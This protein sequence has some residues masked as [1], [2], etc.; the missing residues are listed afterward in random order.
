MLKQQELQKN[1]KLLELLQKKL[2][3]LLRPLLNKQLL[4]KRRDNVLL[5]NK[6]SRD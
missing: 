6:R 4:R 5:L 2:R 1:R 3:L